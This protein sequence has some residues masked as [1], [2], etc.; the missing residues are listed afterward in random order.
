VTF[1]LK[2]TEPA[3]RGPDIAPPS[4]ADGIGAAFR[5][6]ARSVNQYWN[7]GRAK[8]QE[9]VPLAK[10]AAE[11]I[12][13]EALNTHFA[14][15]DTGLMGGVKPPRAESVQD[16]IDWFGAE[17]VLDLAR[18]EAQANPD[19]WSDLDL[20]EGGIEARTQERLRADDAADA[21]MIAL[22][23]API[24]NSII[25]SLG[26]GLV[27]PVNLAL[28]P[29][30]LGSG[31][32]L[33]VIGREALLGAT[34]EVIEY[35]TRADM[36]E[37]LGKPAPSLLES[38]AYGA[39]GGAVLGGAIEGIPRAFQAYRLYRDATRVERDRTVSAPT[40]EAAIQKAEAAIVSG[41]D[42]VRAA[43]DEILREPAPAL[44]PLILD[45]SMSVT[46]R[47][48]DPTPLAP[49][50]ITTASLP[51][52]SEPPVP[53][54]YV[55]MY[56]GGSTKADG[57]PLPNTFTTD[58]ALA[59]KYSGD[60]RMFY[61]DVP[62]T[63]DEVEASAINDFRTSLTRTLDPEK[64]GGVKEATTTAPTTPGET[65]ALAER[66]L[67]EA[68]PKPV[69]KRALMWLKRN[70][71]VDPGSWLANELK[72]RGITHKSIPGLFRKGG[73]REVDNLVA[74]EME[75][76]IPGISYRAGVDNVYLSRDGF[77]GVID[78]EIRGYDPEAPRRTYSPEYRPETSYFDATPDERG[79]MV[80]L[81]RYQFDDPNWQD[82]LKGDFD[83]YLRDK[84]VTLLPRE[85]DEVLG[86]V[87]ARGGD[88]D[89]LLNS[90]QS[91][92][93]DEADWA[94]LRAMRGE[95]YGRATADEIPIG[96]EESLGAGPGGAGRGAVAEPEAA[97]R[98]AAQPAAR[99]REP[100]GV[101]RTAI[102]DQY[103]IPGTDRVTPDTRARDQAE[104]AARQIQSKIGRLNQSRV[105]D[106]V[107]GL[108][109]AKQLDIFDSLNAPEGRRFLDVNV[110]ALRD[111]LDG[112]GDIILDAPIAADDGR[113]LNSLSDV[114]AE[115]DDEDALTREFNLCLTGGGA[116]E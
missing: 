91:R 100:P 42:P 53:D 68:S 45:P 69:P 75:E 82:R 84:S 77:M 83:T 114:L 46:A 66:A 106:D 9:Q 21:E 28:I 72:A 14:T 39:V 29:F 54:G 34:A 51:P 103:L 57:D 10:T 74:S 44:R 85:Y 67:N 47:T 60:G 18:K 16:V 90:V 64:F 56:H 13:L 22:S 41:G 43:A 31:S 94:T 116:K 58:R 7:I 5:S 88:V 48:P 38:A 37:Y 104:I 97:A 109:A 89:D 102:G 79:W 101:E 87:Q 35:P 15:G 63:A 59:E 61:V 40:Q 65:A 30:G 98:D 6:A 19:R 105:E 25:G 55:R 93:L 24:R 62:K 111:I 23:P 110:Q 81:N 80:D 2:Q 96:G 49:D 33:R 115:I 73:R 50:P 70:G 8:D 32:L 95:A 71:G 76:A 113:A 108:F 12:G 4:N 17:T 11:R 26:A 27:D 1:F 99:D 3:A 86:I 20:S 107:D 36:A 112:E 78:D 52:P 92:A